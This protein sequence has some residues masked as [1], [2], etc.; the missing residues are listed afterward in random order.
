[1]DRIKS[2]LIFFGPILIP[3][4]INLYR[5]V[6]AQAAHRPASR[7]LPDR[8]NRALNVLFVSILVFL[9]LSLP[10]KPHAPSP[11][12]FALTRSR[13]NT[14]TDVL[15][16]RL[17][18]LR[19]RQSLTP[20]DAVLRSKLTSLAARNL[21]L[22]FG[23]D[24]LTSC[25]FC[26]P[27]HPDSYLIYYLPFNVLLPHLCHMLVVGLVTT[28]SFAGREAAAWRPTFTVAGLLLAALDLYLVVTY[29]PVR[30]ASAA[31]RASQ[32][33]P[34]SFYH[35]ITLLRPLLLMVFDVLCALLVYLSATNRFWGSSSS[36]ERPHAP[37]QL[38]QLVSATA[39]SLTV[40]SS[41][42][43]A[44]SVARNAVLRDKMLKRRDDVYWQ[45]VVAVEA[46]S[47]Q[48]GTS[49]DNG[50]AP[51]TPSSSSVWEDEEVVRAMSRAM[52]GHGG[53]DLARLN[54]S[55]NDYVNK[56]TSELDG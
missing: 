17:A 16:S 36:M 52:A 30:S 56:I 48:T 24:P 1:M 25:Q 6:R 2:L 51:R 39:S 37:D 10:V 54:A 13:L 47:A 38:D 9:V 53:V 43:H 26:S 33:P 55:A 15:F 35:R 11:N 31:V 28:A 34:A 40:A 8:A 41:R 50:P 44:L 19:P 45:T 46:R 14:P 29:D 23:P 42:L 18:R 21:Y 27:D 22:K 12:V 32:A 5:T 20:E 3:R 49:P 7:P 4:A